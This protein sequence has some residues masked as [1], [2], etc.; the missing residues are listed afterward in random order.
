MIAAS[1]H[2]PNS[3]KEKTL[4]LLSPP[5]LL[6]FFV[7]LIFFSI[8]LFFLLFYFSAMCA[9][10][11]CCLFVCEPQIAPPFFISMCVFSMY[12]ATFLQCVCVHLSH[13]SSAV[14]ISP[15]AL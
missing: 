3:V 13:A 10:Y 5:L 1:F 12:A 2:S 11:L 9:V 4:P 6:Y 15:V 8:F 14:V 7:F